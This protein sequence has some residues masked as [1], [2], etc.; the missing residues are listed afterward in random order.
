MIALNL[1]VSKG[2]YYL[3]AKAR[4]KVVGRNKQ[5]DEGA[6]S[7]CIPLEGLYSCQKLSCW[8]SSLWHSLPA[9]KWGWHQ[10]SPMFC[11]VWYYLTQ[12]SVEQTLAKTVP[13]FKSE[14]V[15]VL[16]SLRSFTFW[17]LAW[18]HWHDQDQPSINR[19]P[20]PNNPLT[21]HHALIVCGGVL[22]VG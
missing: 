17:Q 1:Q 14:V 13:V 16:S 5:L 4:R 6:G 20:L 15:V 10:G 9:W 18:T 22:V 2:E 7:I 3:L 12:S 19:L 11:A 21:T 8:S